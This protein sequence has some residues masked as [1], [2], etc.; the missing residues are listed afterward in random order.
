MFRPR[1]VLF[2]ILYPNWPLVNTKGRVSMQC[3]SLTI[4][5]CSSDN[6]LASTYELSAPGFPKPD[7]IYSVPKASL[8]QALIYLP[9]FSRCPFYLR[10]FLPNLLPTDF[11][12]CLL[13]FGLKQHLK[14]V[15][16]QNPGEKISG[17]I[18]HAEKERAKFSL[19]LRLEKIACLG[20]S[21]AGDLH[22]TTRKPFVQPMWMQREQFM[23][24]SYH[25]AKRFIASTVA[26]KLLLR[27]HTAFSWSANHFIKSFCCPLTP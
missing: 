1:S 7:V 19:F 25:P 8:F 6:F 15:S 23:C 4:F 2:G 17:I 5:S 26:G 9:N 24:I 27:S 13:I 10:C 12:G 21:L 16:L 22:T 3:N 11:G 14:E 20:H 18:L